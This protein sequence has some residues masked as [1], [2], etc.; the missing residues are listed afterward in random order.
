MNPLSHKYFL[1]NT[2]NS[3]PAQVIA[4]GVFIMI[5]H[6]ISQLGCFVSGLVTI[7]KTKILLVI[8]Y[9]KW[10]N[11][12]YIRPNQHNLQIKVKYLKMLQTQI[13]DSGNN[14]IRQHNNQ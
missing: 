11:M 7:N 10:V 6:S 9:D 2:D 13:M 4:F 12:V 14:S 5:I 8:G 1:V 3:V